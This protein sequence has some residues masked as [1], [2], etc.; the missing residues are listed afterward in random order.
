VLLVAIAEDRIRADELRLLVTSPVPLVG[1]AGTCIFSVVVL[2]AHIDHGLL[3]GWAAAMAALTAL[4][5]DL[6]RRFR[7]IA[8][9]DAAVL[10]WAPALT[11]AVALSGL[12]WGLFGIGFYLPSDIEIRGVALLVL[13]SML[14]SG[15][16]FY[17]AYLPAHHAYVVCCA[18]PIAGASFWHGSSSSILF[19]AV[20]FAYIAMILRAARDFHRRIRRTIRTQLENEGLIAGLMAAKDAAE[21][22]NRTKT[23]F[24]ANMSHELRT[25]LNAVIGYS[26]M[27]LEDAENEHREEQVAD[28]RRIN[29]AGQHLLALVN[30]VLDL[31]KIE[32]GRMELS[33]SRLDLRSFIDD[34]LATCRPLIDANGNQLDLIRM[35]ALG[36]IA[37][38]ATKLRQVLLN[39]LGNAAKFTRNGRITVTVRRETDAE[40]EWVA[41]AVHD[42]GIGIDPEVIGK[43][44]HNFT[45]ADASTATKYGGTGLGLALSRKLCRLMGG[46]IAVESEPGRGSCFTMRVPAQLGAAAGHAEEQIR[47]QP[48]AA[49]V[50]RAS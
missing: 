29:G 43:L 9:D 42:T 38:D 33:V 31:S 16:I 36:N 17:S 41:I 34:I 44:F 26:E 11:A 24:L 48:M 46:E 18:L 39:L 40:G 32:A 28:L 14:A 22:A 27:L 12:L 35:P 7:P 50:L 21:L 19:G 49:P 3:L 1:A 10:R 23:Q 25:P 45:Q 5:F 2:W 30:D 15:T 20:T 4:R 8:L 47:E 6:W 13:A 37:G